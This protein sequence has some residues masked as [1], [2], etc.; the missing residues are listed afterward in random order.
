MASEE[1]ALRVAESVRRMLRRVRWLRGVGLS[2]PENSPVVMVY[3][4]ES[5]HCDAARRMLGDALQGVPLAYEAVGDTL[6][7]DEPVITTG[8]VTA[9]VDGADVVMVHNRRYL[10]KICLTGLEATFG[11]SGQVESRL[12]RIGF[13]NVVVYERNP[14]PYFPD[15]TPYPHGV[16]YWA[17]GDWF[18]PDERFARPNEITQAWMVV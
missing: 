10:A 5:S 7:R 14:P 3:V 2:G 11:S 1:Q 17:E 18:G 16:T 6:A 15:R 4:R 13:A 12:N 9:A 8:A